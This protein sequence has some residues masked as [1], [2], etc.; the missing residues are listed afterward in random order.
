LSSYQWQNYICGG[1]LRGK[2]KLKNIGYFTG[3][4]EPGGIENAISKINV[5]ILN[6]VLF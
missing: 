5:V 3:D 4:N 2:K 1:K 6:I